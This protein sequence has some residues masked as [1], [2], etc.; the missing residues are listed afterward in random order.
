MHTH[1]HTHTHT[2]MYTQTC[3][4]RQTHRHMHAH[5]SSADQ[6]TLEGW[7]F[8]N[9]HTHREREGERAMGSAPGMPAHVKALRTHF[10][11]CIYIRLS[12]FTNASRSHHSRTQ[13]GLL[14]ASNLHTDNTCTPNDQLTAPRM[15]G[16][17]EA[18]GMQPCPSNSSR[19][20]RR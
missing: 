7:P 18:F 20:Q 3:R 15:T 6:R 16:W 19:S 9:T 12:T 10:P 14:R 2:H 13:H 1:T 17:S 4:H 8:R 5:T 11:K